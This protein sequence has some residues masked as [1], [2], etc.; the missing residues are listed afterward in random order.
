MFK[1]LTMIKNND[2]NF[3]E[4]SKNY[5]IREFCPTKKKKKDKRV[6]VSFVYSRSKLTIDLAYGSDLV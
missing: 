4:T 6:Y 2:K 1:G 5:Q 3:D